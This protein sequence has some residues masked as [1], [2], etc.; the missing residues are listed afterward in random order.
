MECCYIWSLDGEHVNIIVQE[1]LTRSLLRRLWYSVCVFCY[2]RSRSRRRNRFAAPTSA[3][4]PPQSPFRNTLNFNPSS[5]GATAN[6]LS[7]ATVFPTSKPFNWNRS[8]W[9]RVFS[10]DDC[11][12]QRA[13]TAGGNSPPSYNARGASGPP[14]YDVVRNSDYEKFENR[15]RRNRRDT[16]G[17]SGT[18]SVCN[19][20]DYFLQKNYDYPNGTLSFIY[21]IPEISYL[22]SL[23]LSSSHYLHHYRVQRI[24]PV[25]VFSINGSL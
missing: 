19:S 24:L 22:S 17:E 4:N 23:L 3:V 1:S 10:T 13:A 18:C 21:L 14:V 2:R 5:S 8:Q 25:A 9:K 12:E 6:N 7:S 20:S 15:S 16:F 11:V